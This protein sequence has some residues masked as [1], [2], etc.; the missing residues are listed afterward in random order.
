ML[1]DTF[2][3]FNL[4][5][6]SRILI[7]LTVLLIIFY[8]NKIFRYIIYIFLG[9]IIYLFRNGLDDIDQD[10]NK[11]ISPSSSTVE[12][13][14]ELEE[15]MHYFTYVSLLDKYFVI[16]PLDCKVLEINKGLKRDDMERIRIVCVDKYDKE[17]EL[18]LIV[19][20]PTT[21]FGTIIS[22]LPKMFYKNRIVVNCKV[23]DEISKGERIGILRFG[24]NLEYV[25]SKS[26]YMGL[27][28]KEHYKL[29][30]VIGKI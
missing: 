17:F 5:Y 21:A 2:L 23:G 12:S 29:G 1:D 16:A 7:A 15:K 19:K 8:K 30:Q 13:I 22:W 10:K 26:N 27:E 4:I 18:I 28:L 14:K 3:L 24:G 25:F 6:A 20:K 9:I 11:I